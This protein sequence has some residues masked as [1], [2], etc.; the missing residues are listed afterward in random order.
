MIELKQVRKTYQ[1]G[2][3]TV[4]AIDG[5]D[6][7]VKEGEF[8]AIVGPSG[9]GKS[10][11]M[12][13]IGLLDEPDA[14]EYVLDGQSTARLSDA[15]LAKIRNRK[16]GF[17]FQSFNLLGKLSAL[18]NVKLPLSYAGVRAKEADARARNLLARVGL[19]GREHHLPNQLSGGQQQRVAVARA[20]VCQP[21]IILADE[22]T[23]ALDSRTGEEIM[24][25]FEELHAEGQTVILI[26]H[27]PDLAERAPRTVR[28]ADGR[29]YE[30]KE[31]AHAV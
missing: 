19:E 21:E 23:G 3:E 29:V 22:P 13:I 20:L 15:R 14:G 2:G 27:N 5:V 26:T 6:F 11:L 17:V 1:L 25:L 10:S 30:E 9:S 4:H 28:I 31:A 12:N 7:R 8:V 16:I 18:E 24:Q